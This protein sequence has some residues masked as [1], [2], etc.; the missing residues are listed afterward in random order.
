MRI[1]EVVDL[2]VPLANYLVRIDKAV[3]FIEECKTINEMRVETSAIKP[4]ETRNESKPDNSTFKR[5]GNPG[6][7]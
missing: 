3:P 7:R 1:G 2:P 4:V 6:R 5:T